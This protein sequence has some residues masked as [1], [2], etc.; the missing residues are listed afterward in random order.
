MASRPPSCH[1]TRVDEEPT[2]TTKGRETE[3]ETVDRGVGPTPHPPNVDPRDP[4]DLRDPRLPPSYF[5]FPPLIDPRNGLFESPYSGNQLVNSTLT[6]YK[7]HQ[8]VI[9][10][11]VVLKCSFDLLV[12]VTK[13]SQSASMAK[14]QK[15]GTC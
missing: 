10:F 5:G 7:T 8:V 2:T 3:I 4:R 13:I 15:K 1:L 12:T 14:H 6:I 9:C 11:V